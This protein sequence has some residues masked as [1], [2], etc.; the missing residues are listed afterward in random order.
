LVYVAFVS[1]F[2]P[3]NGISQLTSD[4]EALQVAVN[5]GCGTRKRSCC[6]SPEG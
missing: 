2:Q 3:R 1:M 6:G 4:F 5:V